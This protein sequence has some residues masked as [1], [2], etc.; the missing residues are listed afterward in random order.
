MAARRR[1]S[2]AASSQTLLVTRRH[3]GFAALPRQSLATSATPPHSFPTPQQPSHPCATINTTCALSTL[4]CSATSP[5]RLSS[6]APA[7][8]ITPQTTSWPTRT[9]PRFL[10]RRTTSPHPLDCAQSEG[11]CRR[12]CNRPQHITVH[13]IAYTTCRQLSCMDYSSSYPSFLLPLSTPVLC[14]RTFVLYPVIT[15][16]SLSLCALLCPY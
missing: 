1:R 13:T 7:L 3:R 12:N 16:C 4:M 14:S 9:L 5:I 6:R 10:P 11:E 8:C 15:G 2:I